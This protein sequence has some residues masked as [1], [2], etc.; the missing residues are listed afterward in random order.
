M[1]I[2]LTEGRVLLH[3]RLIH[4]IGEGG[5][6]VVWRATDTTLGRD[7]A[8]KVLPDAFVA[9]PERVARFEREARLLA[10]LN[11]PH[12]ASIYGFHAADG[13]RFLVM[14]LVEGETL[15]ARIE[16]GAI[17]PGEALPIALQIASALEHA[18]ERGVV[19]RDLKPGNVVL[20]EG[21]GAKVLDFGLAKAFEGDAPETGSS[22]MMARSP[23]I[24]SRM[25]AP[26]TLLGT[27]AYMA[28][29]QARGQVADRRADI[30]AF[31][32]VVMEMLTGQRLFV[33]ETTSDTLAAVLREDPDWTKLPAATPPRIRAL[34]RRCLTRDPKMRLRDIGEARIAVEQ[35]LSGVPDEPGSGIVPGAAPAGYPPP[36]PRARIRTLAWVAVTLVAIA[37]I[38]WGALRVAAPR[39]EP[40][41]RKFRLVAKDDLGPASAPAISPDGRMALF[42]AGGKLWVQPLDQLESEALDVEGPVQT[43]FWSPDGEWIGYMSGTRILKVPV[44]GGKS[45]VVCDARAPFTFGSGGCWSDRGTIVFSLADSSGILEVS[46]QGGDP[47]TL[48]LPD[49]SESDMH[50]PF[51]LPGGRGVLFCGHRHTGGFNNIQVWSDGK[52]KVLLELRDHSLSTPVYAPSGHILFQRSAPTAGI[53]ALPFSL[54]RLETTGTPFLVV[55][56]GS[57]PSVSRDGTLCFAGGQGEQPLQ[58]A[59]WSRDGKELGTVGVPEQ[60]G[61]RSVGVASDGNRIARSIRTGDNSDIWILDASRGTR[62][63]LT[64]EP[65]TELFPVWTPDGARI[66]YTSAPQQLGRSEQWRILV[67]SSDGGGVPDTIGQ[68][69]DP[70]V[71]PD[72]RFAL[73][74]SPPGGRWNIEA[75]DLDGGSPITVIRGN[76]RAVHAVVSPSGQYIAYMSDESSRWEVYLARFPSGEGKWQI[77]AAGGQWPH[78]NRRGDRLTFTQGDDMMEVDVQ[79]GP[80]PVLGKPVRLF[81]RPA[82]GETGFGFTSE[83]AAD[84]DGSRFLILRPATQGTPIRRVTLVQSW[85]AEFRGKK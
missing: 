62:T 70:T 8:I 41:L 30:W 73:F 43:P 40:P 52:R 58:L 31:G 72:G 35:T 85:Y 26:N 7:V 77:S 82:T 6:G 57:T 20:A 68:G 71:S 50:Q 17:A 13:V 16:R 12:I 34:L 4:S 66:V 80:T 56:D 3:Y 21:G 44:R 25:T 9:D 23:T 38:A 83:F 15:A 84:P 59:W 45:Q 74:T 37:A 47:K 76:P 33:G 60:G 32:V 39:A 22:S 5:M 19:H 54:A 14:E 67:R 24:T 27:A 29:E 55:P 79:T 11:H 64:F 48:C 78:W 10:S 63:R 2:S 53:W 42:L 51:V 81:T 36:S 28:P 65:G 1:S 49:S 46:P 75:V 61:E 69:L 18:H